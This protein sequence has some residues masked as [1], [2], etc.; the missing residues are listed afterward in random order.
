MSQDLI[1]SEFFEVENVI[2]PYSI[3]ISTK[4]KNKYECSKRITEKEFFLGYFLKNQ[5][6]RLSFFKCYN[7]QNVLKKER[8]SFQGITVAFDLESI[9][10][11]KKFKVN[12]KAVELKKIFNDIMVFKYDLEKANNLIKKLDNY[13]SFLASLLKS[14]LYMISGNSAKTEAILIE[15]MGK[16]I[17][18]HALSSDIQL[19]KIQDQIEV[20]LAILDKFDDDLENP[21]LLE[22]FIAYLFYGT[23]G[24]FKRELD[25]E[26]TI[27]RGLSYVRKNYQSV[28]FGKPFPFVWGSQVFEGGSQIE[29]DKFIESGVV[30]ERLLSGESKYI[31]FFRSIDGINSKYKD[32]L[33]KQTKAL[34]KNSDFYLKTVLFRMLDNQHFYRFF[35]AHSKKKVGLIAN[36]K[37]DFYKDKIKNGENVAFSL[38][39]L[40]LLGDLNFQYIL[41]FIGHEYSRL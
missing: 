28:Q 27:D 34:K 3:S 13:K 14:Y 1:Q 6:E 25:S 20:T 9:E 5:D 12:D 11:I 39:Q 26:L 10:E 30:G 35:S 21:K 18:E 16:E 37:R 31:L 22:L 40:T 19:M 8:L 29:Y 2:T 38:A 17:F 32:S 15:L 23:T 4:L 7:K 36:L 24:S 41:K 33:I